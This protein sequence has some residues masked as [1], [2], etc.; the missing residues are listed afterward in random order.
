MLKWF[1]AEEDKQGRGQEP[2]LRTGGV[3]FGVEALALPAP[4]KG[5]R[6]SVPLAPGFARE[7]QN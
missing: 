4:A 5:R 2:A 1:H 3:G 6:R 7:L